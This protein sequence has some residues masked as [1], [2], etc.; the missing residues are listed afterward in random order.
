[1]SSEDKDKRTINFYNKIRPNYRQVHVD[2]A[3][4]GITP[5]GL[6]SIQFFAERFPLPKST[7]F[8][9]NE[10][11]LGEKISEEKKEGI[12]REYDFGVYMDLQTAKEFMSWLSNTIEALE[13]VKNINDDNDS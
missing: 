11:K 13:K 8:E 2:G 10:E 5:R 4:G 6:I 1:M 9:I 3:F 7:T 12:I